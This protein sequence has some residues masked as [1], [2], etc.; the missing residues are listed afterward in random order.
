MQSNNF[1]GICQ[2]NDSIPKGYCG[3]V[4]EHVDFCGRV[5]PRK[6][7]KGEGKLIITGYFCDYWLTYLSLSLEYDHNPSESGICVA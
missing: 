3:L 2:N 4:K 1:E 7:V 6:F 5:Q